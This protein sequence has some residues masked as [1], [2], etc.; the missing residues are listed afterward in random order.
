MKE[1]YEKIDANKELPDKPAWYF[2]GC[3][4]SE[5]MLYWN[6]NH[7]I[8]SHFNPTFW[9]KS[10]TAYSREEVVELLEKYRHDRYGF[11]LEQWL[12]ENLKK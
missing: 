4:T 1:Y 7:W 11:P 8:D 6:G 5:S 9:L 3:N 2:G 12:S 10:C